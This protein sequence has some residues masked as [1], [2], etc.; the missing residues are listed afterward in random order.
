MINIP[1]RNNPTWHHIV[2]FLGFIHKHLI[3]LINLL[4]CVLSPSTLCSVLDFLSRGK[5]D[6]NHFRQYNSGLQG[7]PS[8]LNRQ[9]KKSVSPVWFITI[10]V[11]LGRSI[12][13]NINMNIFTCHQVVT[14]WF[15]FPFEQ[16][17]QKICTIGTGGLPLLGCLKGDKYMFWHILVGQFEF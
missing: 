2:K 4:H 8:L 12:N 13:I 14:K 11:P 5:E 1:S 16:C 17:Q 3:N 7:Q 15:P 10:T 9:E 6:V